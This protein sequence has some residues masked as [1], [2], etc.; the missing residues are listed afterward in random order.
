MKAIER[1]QESVTKLAC[2]VDTGRSADFT[3]AAET[4]G[5]TNIDMA[6]QVTNS[7]PAGSDGITDIVMAR[8]DTDNRSDAATYERGVQTVL[9]PTV[10]VATPTRPNTAMRKRS[11]GGPCGPAVSEI[12]KSNRVAPVESF[13][14][15][16]VIVTGQNFEP[17]PS[18]STDPAFL[19]KKINNFEFS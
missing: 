10:S 4:S 2:R 1:K 17:V 15:T 16:S 11:S 13:Q 18:T 19:C 14:G 9:A 6:R 5:N 8:Q 3:N 7:R 12:R